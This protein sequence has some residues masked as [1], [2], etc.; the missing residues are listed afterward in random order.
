MNK[1][2]GTAVKKIK[3]CQ[4]LSVLTAFHS[5]CSYM[6][7]PVQEA[8]ADN[9]SENTALTRLESRLFRTLSV[10]SGA[11]GACWAE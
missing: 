11:Q 2:T 4:W 9:L 5:R 8:P 6:R 3:Q 7:L 10:Q 1:Y